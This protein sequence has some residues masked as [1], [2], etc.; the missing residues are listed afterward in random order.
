MGGRED[1]A[2]IGKKWILD[3]LDPRWKQYNVQ[4]SAEIRHQIKNAS[5]VSHLE[6][7]GGGKNPKGIREL[8]L[9]KNDVI[10]EAGRDLEDDELITPFRSS[11][12]FK[13]GRIR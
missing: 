7:G 2:A 4:V 1:Y 3:L 12:I 8:L 10:M 5:R 6:L 11:D 9:C 13:N